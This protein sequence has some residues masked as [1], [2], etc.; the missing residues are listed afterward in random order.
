MKTGKVN[1]HTV[2]IYDSIDELPIQRFQKYNKYMLI[3]SGV[4]SDLQDVLNHIDRAKIY[5]KSNPAMAAT[6]LDNMRQSIYL[7]VDELSPKHMAFAALVHKIDGEEMNDISDAGLKRVL[8]ILSEA[9]KGWLDGV[10]SS[11]KKKN[12]P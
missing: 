10:L 11:V 12:R 8:E 3:D 4:G 1:K 6:E 2:E 7:L 5:I 9:K